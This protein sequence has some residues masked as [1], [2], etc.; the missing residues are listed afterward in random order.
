MLGITKMTVDISGCIMI[1][2]LYSTHRADLKLNG[3]QT[4]KQMI[5]CIK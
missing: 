4:N 5:Y 2:M 1:S 3:K